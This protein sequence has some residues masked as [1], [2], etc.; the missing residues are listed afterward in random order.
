MPEAAPLIGGVFRLFPEKR[1][2]LWV[3]AAAEIARRRAD[4]RFVIWGQGVLEQELR[5]RIRA[6]GLDDRLVLAGVTEDALAAISALDIFMLTSFKEG[7]PNVV[8][9]AQRVGTPVVAVEAGGTREALEPGRT[10]WI[11]DPPTASGLAD[12]ICRL[13]DDPAVRAECLSA[14]PAF[15]E[16][17]F[18][19]GRMVEDTLAAYGFDARLAPRRHAGAA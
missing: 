15:V 19:L 9:E 7:T 5:D 2:M 13:L 6:C 3:E 14:G 18:G 17:R 10:G 12:Q 4:A 1:P 16:A 11:V 8:L